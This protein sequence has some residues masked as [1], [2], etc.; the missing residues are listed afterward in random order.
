LDW[1]RG[2]VSTFVSITGEEYKQTLVKF[3]LSNAMAQCLKEMLATIHQGS[4]GD[5]T[6]IAHADDL[7]FADW[8]VQSLNPAITNGRVF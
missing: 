5:E 1:S 4:I 7:S 8:I 3:G 6:D 2:P